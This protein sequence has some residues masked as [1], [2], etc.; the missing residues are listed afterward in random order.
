MK[1]ARRILNMKSQANALRSRK[2]L[3]VHVGYRLYQHTIVNRNTVT[4]KGT[5]QFFWDAVQLLLIPL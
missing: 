3:K 5:Q 4:V 2:H 1:V